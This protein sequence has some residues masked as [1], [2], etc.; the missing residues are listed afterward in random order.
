MGAAALL[1]ELEVVVGQSHAYGAR[2]LRCLLHVD[3][4]LDP[5]HGAA[6]VGFGLARAR[7]RLGR[8]RRERAQRVADGRPQPASTIQGCFGRGLLI[9]CIAARIT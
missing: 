5:G 1:D 2:R 7:I 9:K 4:F 8:P 6:P 3:G